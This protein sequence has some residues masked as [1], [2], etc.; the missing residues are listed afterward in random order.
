MTD[1]AIMAQWAKNLLNDD[2]FKEVIDNLKKE[3]SY[4]SN[5]D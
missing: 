3:Q 2:F 1:K 5:I 4:L